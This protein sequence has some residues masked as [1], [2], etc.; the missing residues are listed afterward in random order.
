MIQR[1]LELPLRRLR[2]QPILGNALG[3]NAA[4]G[5]IGTQHLRSVSQTD[6][7]PANG[8][9]ATA[10]A[11]VQL[12]VQYKLIE[13]H[14]K[15]ERERERAREREPERASARA[16]ARARTSEYCVKPQF[17]HPAHALFAASNLAAHRR[18]SVL[19]HTFG[20]GLKTST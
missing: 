19:A 15:K 13:M 14:A 5:H 18:S 9:E 10:A 12:D 20:L 4:G 17:V 8:S 11:H 16:R 6:E 3:E 2:I 1:Y 7:A